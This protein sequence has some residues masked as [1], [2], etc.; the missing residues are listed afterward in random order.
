M[1]ARKGAQYLL[2]L[3][4]PER[5]ITEKDK[6]EKKQLHTE[7]RRAIEEFCVNSRRQLL[8]VTQKKK[9]ITKPQAFI[10]NAFDFIERI[11]TAGDHN[12]NKKTFQRVKKEVVGISRADVQWLLEHCQV[13]MMNW[14]NTTQALLQPIVVTEVLGRVQADLIDIRTKL[15][16]EHMWIL[17]LKNYFSKFSMLY[18]LTNKRTSEITYYISLF[19]RNLGIPGILQFDNGRE[20]Q[21]ALLLF[22]KK[23]NIRLA[24]RRP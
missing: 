5:K 3:A 1:N 4:Y 6:A 14:Q 13:C 15:D 2:F 18:A 23:H 9:D 16:G 19:V 21:E 22:L 12:G 24:N 17:P 8:H 7:K 20:F 10:Y 11:Y